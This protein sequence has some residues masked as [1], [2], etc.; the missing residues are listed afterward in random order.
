MKAQYALKS[1]IGNAM[2]HGYEFSYTD[3]DHGTKGAIRVS[4]NRILAFR[5]STHRHFTIS[6]KKQIR[7]RIEQCKTVAR[8]RYVPKLRRPQ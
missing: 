1:L 5:F 7:E 4:K 8:A 2:N 3:L 6:I